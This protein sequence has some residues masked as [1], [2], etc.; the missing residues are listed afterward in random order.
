MFKKYGW[1]FGLRIAIS[2]AVFTALGFVAKAMFGS[3]HKMASDGFNSFGSMFPA[4]ESA[5]IF[6]DNAGNIVD[7][8]S[9]GLDTSSFVTSGSPFG[10]SSFSISSSMP[11]PFSIFCNFI[12]G[13][14]LVMLIGGALLAWYLKKKGQENL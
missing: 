11:E 9:F 3:M 13:M 6:Y 12:I 8:G 7:P 2:G 10:F 5:M 14:G 4:N 1:I